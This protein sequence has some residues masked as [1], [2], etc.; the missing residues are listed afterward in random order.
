MEPSRF[1]T[2]SPWPDPALEPL[3]ALAQ[4]T[5]VP[6]RLLDWTSSRQVAAYFA[7]VDALAKSSDT[8]D[9]SALNWRFVDVYGDA[10]TTS[11]AASFELTGT[12]TQIST[13][14]LDCSRYVAATFGTTMASSSVPYLRDVNRPSACRSN[15]SAVIWL[16]PGS[17]RSAAMT[18][19]TSPSPN[20]SLHS[21]L[22][23][24]ACTVA[25]STL[26]GSP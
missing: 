2:G 1:A 12:A 21:A 11:S 9:V 8:L 4:H 20:P 23:T 22:N 10:P 25:A 13:R 15:S 24:F 3:L 17:R 6:T 16:I 14:R 7:A 19:R 18:R 26:R 5:G